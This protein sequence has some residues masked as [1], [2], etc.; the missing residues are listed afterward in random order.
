MTDTND[1]Q[2][3]FMSHLIELRIRL[4][5]SIIAVVVVGTMRGELLTLV[6]LLVVGLTN[7]ISGSTL[8]G[9]VLSFMRPES[10]TRPTTVR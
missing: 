9:L 4:M 5:R 2:E 3:S 6:G 8:S 7:I 10:Q 1:V